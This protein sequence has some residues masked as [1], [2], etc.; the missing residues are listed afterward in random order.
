MSENCAMQEAIGKA[1]MNH[2]KSN[3]FIIVGF[4]LLI[5]EHGVQELFQT[6]WRLNG[7]ALSEYPLGN[8]AMLNLTF[9]KPGRA[10]FS[11]RGAIEDE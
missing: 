9:Q 7:V 3:L 11:S 1:R 10:W 8:D 2:G 6:S 5:L 4:Y